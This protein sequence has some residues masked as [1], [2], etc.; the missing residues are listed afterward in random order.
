MKKKNILNDEENV[1]NDK[2]DKNNKNNKNKKNKKNNFK[3][4]D[5]KINN[6]ILNNNT[7]F[8]SENRIEME[9]F[10]KDKINVLYE[11]SEEKHEEKETL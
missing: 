2:I 4:L 3:T 6:N 7:S 1:K 9:S 5:N 10:D 8:E 11:I